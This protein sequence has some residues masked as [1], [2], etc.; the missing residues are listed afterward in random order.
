MISKNKIKSIQALRLKKNRD[1]SQLFVLEGEKMVQ[2]IILQAPE[3]LVCIYHTTDFK[4]PKN[5]NLVERELISEQE[6]KQISSLQTPNKCL[7]VV[8]FLNF[9]KNDSDFFLALD[10]VQDPGNMGTILRL[11]DWFGIQTLFCSQETVDVY[12]PKVVQASMGAILRV[13]VEY[14]D[15]KTKFE[16][17]NLPV[18]GALLE[19]KNVYHEK[20][21]RKGILLLGNEGKGISPELQKSITH[22]IHIP[23]F[24][25]AESL[26]VA[27]AT[28]ILISEFFRN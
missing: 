19:G 22:P 25:Q 21:T 10:G 1:S 24:G 14:V 3:Q 9:Q 2:E 26:N 4:F 18:Y 13:A 17:L 8:R 12:N 23:R 28:G 15:L 11:A 16:S 7:A 5:E 20:L 27:V 6:L